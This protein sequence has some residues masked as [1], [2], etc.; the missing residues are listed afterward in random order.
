MCYISLFYVYCTQSFLEVRTFNQLQM[1]INTGS[2][3]L[4]VGFMPFEPS[5]LMA[6]ISINQSVIGHL[7]RDS[8]L[9]ELY[10][11]AQ[12]HLEPLS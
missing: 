3:D 5:G 4:E 12:A 10:P 7:V 2:K 6:Q 8:L 9:A 11:R 1:L